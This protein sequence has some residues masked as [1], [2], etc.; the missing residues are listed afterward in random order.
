[1]KLAILGCIVTRRPVVEE[2]EVAE[3]DA[4]E[5]V[6][7]KEVGAVAVAVVVVVAVQ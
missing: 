5:E 2:K 1:M 7:E 3:V 6:V 4:K